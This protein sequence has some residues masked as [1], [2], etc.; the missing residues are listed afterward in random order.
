MNSTEVDVRSDCPDCAGLLG[1]EKG[2]SVNGAC[3]DC[4][5]TGNLYIDGDAS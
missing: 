1:R 2:S 3:L 4:G 5:W